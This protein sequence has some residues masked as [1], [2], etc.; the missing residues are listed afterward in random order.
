[1]FP[2]HPDTDERGLIEATARYTGLS[3]ELI[4][5]D[6]RSSILAPALEHI[7]RWSLPPVTP[8]LF[9]WRPLMASARGHGVD[10]MLD[11]EGGDELFG[12]A[13]FL[14]ADLLRSGRLLAA[15]RLTRRIPEVGAE[16]DARLRLRAIRKYGAAP[17]LPSAVKRWRARGRE[18][19]AP[20]SLLA[21]ADVAAL[22]ALAREEE[23]EEGASRGSTARSGGGHSRRS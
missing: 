18:A 1:M 16:A 21:A 15:W 7:A 5:F 17:L 13:P 12:W 8:N 14:F 4:S 20:G 6:D 10:V 23:E 3:V 11:G 22:A 2:D 19:S 9:V